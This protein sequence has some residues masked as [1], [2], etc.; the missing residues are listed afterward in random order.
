M[1]NSFHLLALLYLIF[2]VSIPLAQA[3]PKI[4][5]FQ[6]A[7]FSVEVEKLQTTHEYQISVSSAAQ[8]EPPID[9]D[10]FKIPSPP[11]LV[12]DLTGIP[13]PTYFGKDLSLPILSRVR[14]DEFEGKQ[15]IVLVFAKDYELSVSNSVVR[16]GLVEAR[17]TVLPKSLK[18]AEEEVNSTTSNNLE[19]ELPPILVEPLLTPLTM[20]IPEPTD[21]E[22][23]PRVSTQPES[24]PSV[25]PAKGTETNTK[26]S[27]EPT[28]LVT[29]QQYLQSTVSDQ[30]LMAILLLVA[31]VSISILLFSTRRKGNSETKISFFDDDEPIVD[32]P[33]HDFELPT[34]HEAYRVLGCHK[35]DSDQKL[36]AHYRRLIKVFHEDKLRSKELPRELL[37]VS[38]RE[39]DKVRAAFERLRI[40]R[41]SL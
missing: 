18:R 12:I 30:Q 35:N 5:L 41:P 34:L 9:A 15:R 25:R 13:H 24:V 4:L 7:S 19:A 3:L 27:T 31:L 10:V 16:D 17:V 21:T 1:K 2:G 29:V 6:N 33:L 39:F 37:T 28:L 32:L 40:E 22:E 14:G 20:S 8:S 23:A 26:V 11:R 38:R 36:K